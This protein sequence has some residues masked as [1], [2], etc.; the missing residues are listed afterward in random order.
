M[1]ALITGIRGAAGTYLAEYLRGNGI[2]VSG[3][4]RPEC[5]MVD[6]HAVYAKL[7]AVRPDVIYHLASDANV[8]DAF[9]NA[10]QVFT[11][12]AA[13]TVTLFEAALKTGLDPL[14]MV[15]SSSEV[16]GNPKVYPISEGFRIQPSNPYA[17]SKA[18]QDL[19]GQMYG[20][21]YGMRVVITRSFSYVNPL[22]R[23][24][25]LSHFARQIVAVERGEVTEI[26]H[27]NL[28]SVRSFCDVRD[29]VAAYARLPTLPTI[30]KL[31]DGDGIYN[32][33]GGDR[34]SIGQCLEMLMGLATAP[35]KTRQDPALM[36]QTDVTN[37]IPDCSL[38]RRITGWE[39]KIPL[40]DSL[41]WLLDHYRAA[42]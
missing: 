40:R 31:N 34:V 22:R 23:D 29:V 7:V 35:I 8:R 24:L 41:A 14:I 39:P 12:N 18:A 25:A 20:R 11:N 5:D 27:G 6:F 33:G 9:D 19:L 42:A 4:A 36:R 3:I 16:Y 30:S 1:R 2:E 32:I 26:V 17:V 13:G 28:D 15:C 38:F 10:A 37:Q 21:G